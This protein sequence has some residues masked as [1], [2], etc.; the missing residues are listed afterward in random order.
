MCMMLGV[1][2]C[3]CVLHKYVINNTELDISI[4]FVLLQTDFFPCGFVYVYV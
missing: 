1:C 4:R 3:L 2:M